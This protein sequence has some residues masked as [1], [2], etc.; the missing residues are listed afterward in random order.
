MTG[1]EFGDAVLISFPFTDQTSTK[2]RPAV[3]VSSA[4][5]HRGR[6]DLIVVAVTG[7]APRST[8]A[9]EVTIASWKQAGRLKPSVVKSVLLTIEAGL[10]LRKLGRLEPEDRRTLHEALLAILG[11]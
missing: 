1:Y 7:Q 3:V 5:Y 9:G 10:V 11:E 4:A 8:L 2:K 6:F